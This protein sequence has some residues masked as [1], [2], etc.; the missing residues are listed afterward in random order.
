[1]LTGK[2]APCP[3]NLTA[4]LLFLGGW[5]RWWVWAEGLGASDAAL[6]APIC[7]PGALRHR[8]ARGLVCWPWPHSTQPDPAPRSLSYFYATTLKK[9]NMTCCLYL[10]SVASPTWGSYTKTKHNPKMRPLSDQDLGGD[11]GSETG[12]CAQGRVT[13]SPP[14]TPCSSGWPRPAPFASCLARR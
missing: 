2:P 14:H 12:M 8:R 4:S 5:H 1:M 6:S 11:W 13:V 7:P 10:K 9:W 3:Q